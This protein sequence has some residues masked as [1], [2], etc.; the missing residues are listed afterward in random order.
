[1]SSI[2]LGFIIVET[3]QRCRLACLQGRFWRVNG[4]FCSPPHIGSRSHHSVLLRAY[5]SRMVW[6]FW[7]AFLDSETNK[8]VHLDSG[9]VYSGFNLATSQYLINSGRYPTGRRASR[10]SPQLLFVRFFV[11][12][13]CSCVCFNHK[14]GIIIESIYLHLSRLRQT[15]QPKLLFL[16]S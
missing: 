15:S 13:W 5:C 14:V 3:E 4:I 10:P 8:H 16:N 12:R 9:N 6:R 2:Q 11:G 7:T 1:M